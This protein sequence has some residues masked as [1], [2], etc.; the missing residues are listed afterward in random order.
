MQV[1]LSLLHE[2]VSVALQIPAAALRGLFNSLF[3]AVIGEKALALNTDPAFHC[4]AGDVIFLDSSPEILDKARAAADVTMHALLPLVWL[5]KQQNPQ[6]M[7][8]QTPN[9]R[10]WPVPSSF[11]LCFRLCF[12]ADCVRHVKRSLK[13]Q[14]DASYC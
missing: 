14:I 1:V 11:S 10:L 8:A 2:A 6:S 12:V 9:Q 7:R 5:M 3:R 4:S 13:I